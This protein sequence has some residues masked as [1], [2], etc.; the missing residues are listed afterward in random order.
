MIHRVSELH[1]DVRH[2]THVITEISHTFFSKRSVTYVAIWQRVTILRRKYLP[3]THRSLSPV[4]QDYLQRKVGVCISLQLNNQCDL[5]PGPN[6][7]ANNIV[8]G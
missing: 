8:V 1:T 2:F 4:D 5:Q 3:K 7:I 6:Y